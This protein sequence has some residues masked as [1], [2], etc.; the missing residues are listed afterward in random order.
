MTVAAEI[1]RPKT[2][3]RPYQV[4]NSAV[5][6]KIREKHG[7]LS[8]MASGF[9]IKI[10]GIP[11]RTSE[12]LYQ[13]CRFPHLPHVQ[14]VIIEQKSPM[15][16]KMKSK[17]HRKNTRCDWDTVRVQIMDW[18][19]RIKLAQ[20]WEKFGHT[21]LETADLDIVEKSRRDDFWGA[22]HVDDETLVGTNVLGRL[23]KQLRERVKS[24]ER[25]ALLY[26]QPLAIQHFDIFGSP[27][28]EIDMR[29]IYRRSESAILTRIDNSQPHVPHTQSRI[30]GPPP[31]RSSRDSLQLPL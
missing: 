14:R 11:I 20:N 27:I 6:H 18:C 9:P 2:K 23:L 1:N 24:E 15:A 16:A 17:P 8:N 25:D 7:G 19:L 3:M 26:V 10:N 13:A 22:K 21:L 12:A 4:S 30:P 29:P 31:I 28:E 5:F